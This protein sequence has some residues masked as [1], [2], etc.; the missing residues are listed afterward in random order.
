MRNEAAVNN[1]VLVIF[2]SWLG[3]RRLFAEEACP[4]DTSA[5]AEGNH[6]VEEDRSQARVVLIRQKLYHTD[7]E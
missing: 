7:Q 3:A 1:R 4:I 6:T 5:S 2:L